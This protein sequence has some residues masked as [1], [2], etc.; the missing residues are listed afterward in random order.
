MACTHYPTFSPILMSLTVF[1]ARQQP[2]ELTHDRGFLV[3]AFLV[4][5][6]MQSDIPGSSALGARRSAMCPRA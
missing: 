6:E 5:C 1:G 2:P 4:V 3:D